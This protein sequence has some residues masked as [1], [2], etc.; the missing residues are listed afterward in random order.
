MAKQYQITITCDE[1]FVADSL[2]DLA[3][4]ME[5]RDELNYTYDVED[6][7]FCATIDEMED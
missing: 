3:N 4:I 7:H 1:H 5:E 6:T 2:R